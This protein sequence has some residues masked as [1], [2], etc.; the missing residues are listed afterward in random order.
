MKRYPM[1]TFLLFVIAVLWVYAKDR[2]T[3]AEL[4]ADDPMLEDWE[5]IMADPKEQESMREHVEWLET[6]DGRNLKKRQTQ[7]EIDLAI[8]EALERTQES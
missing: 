7:R 8:D 1:I 4:L 6:E 3:K 2:K 5:A